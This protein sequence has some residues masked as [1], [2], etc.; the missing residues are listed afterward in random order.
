[1]ELTYQLFTFI[2]VKASLSTLLNATMVSNERTKTTKSPGSQS[3]M[4]GKIT[5]HCTVDQ[6]REEALFRGLDIGTVP[7]PKNVLLQIL[8]D[9]SASAVAATARRKQIDMVK[10]SQEKQKD[11][12]AGA[13]TTNTEERW[14]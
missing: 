5:K 12:D 10:I 14:R 7:L 2:H 3:R 4:P 1:L 11:S 9:G 6:L 13:A 8:G